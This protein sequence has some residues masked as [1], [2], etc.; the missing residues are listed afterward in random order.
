MQLALSS[1]MEMDIDVFNALD[2]SE[3]CEKNSEPK[4]LL[5]LGSPALRNA[6]FVLQMAR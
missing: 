5:Y 2:S 6:Y 4:V 3:P 1:F